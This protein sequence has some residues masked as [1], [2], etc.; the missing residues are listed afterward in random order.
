MRLLRL[1]FIRLC[2]LCWLAALACAANPAIDPDDA[3]ADFFDAAREGDVKELAESI[4]TAGVSMDAIDDDGSTALH[5]ASFGGHVGAVKALLMAGAKTDIRATGHGGTPLHVAV[6]YNQLK[7]AA[8]LLESGSVDVD[9][10]T[11][12]TSADECDSGITPL[13]TVESKPRPGGPKQLIGRGQA[14]ARG[15]LEHDLALE[16]ASG[17]PASRGLSHLVFHI[18][19]SCRQRRSATSRWRGRCSRR[20]RMF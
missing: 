18:G 1:P 3:L 15:S 13:T 16:E 9:A 17:E 4:F 8:A 10:T 19:R 6:H 5:Y 14:E 12:C 20:V 7:V 11:S 2:C